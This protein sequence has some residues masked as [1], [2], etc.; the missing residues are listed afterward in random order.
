MF[1]HLDSLTLVSDREEVSARKMRGSCT[2]RLLLYPHLGHQLLCFSF[3]FHLSPLHS[4]S[5]NNHNDSYPSLLY[6]EVDTPEKGSEQ[7]AVIDHTQ[8]IHLATNLGFFQGE[9]QSK[10]APPVCTY[11]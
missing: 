5:D 9:Q 8:Q 2:K 3:S 6:V 4:L 1:I 10:P 7:C 11:H